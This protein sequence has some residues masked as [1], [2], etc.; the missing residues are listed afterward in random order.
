MQKMLF[1]LGRLS[2]QDVDW[3]AR[4]GRRQEV[5]AGE[6]IIDEGQPTRALFFVLDGRLAVEVRGQAAPVAFME[7]GEIAGE[8]SFVDERPPSATVR[9][10]ETSVVLAVETD[11]LRRHLEE[12]P[13]FAA[14]FY[15][16]VASLLS[17][18]LR[19]KSSSGAA[20]R[21]D[22]LDEDVFGDD[23][24]DPGVLARVAQAGERFERILRRFREA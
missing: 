17:D 22:E 9:A 8:M 18:R 7:T 3:L 2:D 6:T 13:A 20:A 24:L 14:R 10:A 15:L 21:A 1:I 11:L 12:E 19:Q 16:A 23:E 4:V 5:D